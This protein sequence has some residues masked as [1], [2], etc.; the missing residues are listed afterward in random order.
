[1]TSYSRRVGM[2]VVGDLG[3]AGYLPG[4]VSGGMAVKVSHITPGRG[5][6]AVGSHQELGGFFCRLRIL[7]C[8]VTL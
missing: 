5:G 3:P 8:T 2:Y 1:M 6:G 7:L 4:Q